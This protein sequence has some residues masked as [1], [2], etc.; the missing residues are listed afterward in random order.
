MNCL[1]TPHT[2]NTLELKGV[3]KSFGAVSVLRKVSLQFSAGEKVLLLGAN[4][5]GKSTLLRII[6]GLSRAD[7][8]T[9]MLSR[10][11]RI[12]FFSHHLFLYPR[13]TIQENLALFASL[14]GSALDTTEVIASW[15]LKEA[16]STVVSS[17]SKGNQARVALARTFLVPAPVILLDEPTSNLDERGSAQLLAAIESK[18]A[19]GGAPS[20]VIVATHDLH[21]LGGWA[22][23][24]IVMAN[25]TVL[26]DSGVGASRETLEHVIQT[27]RE[28]NR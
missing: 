2:E 17:L 24:I 10:Q 4:G 25:G 3:S 9:V 16:S 20:V 12:A 14:H 27:Y 5:A 26:S 28:S 6:S 13:L 21:R 1:S 7:S 11:G 23:R 15:G 18:G 8:G 19:C 22:N